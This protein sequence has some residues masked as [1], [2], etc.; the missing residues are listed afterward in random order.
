MKLSEEIENLNVTSRD[1]DRIKKFEEL[2]IYLSDKLGPELEFDLYGSTLT[3]T[4]R[5]H[6]DINVQ[7]TDTNQ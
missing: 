3:G 7:V 2:K 6:S 4:W 5:P 1:S